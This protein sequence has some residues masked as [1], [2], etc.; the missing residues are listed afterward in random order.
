MQ[1]EISFDRD[2]ALLCR[3]E[4]WEMETVARCLK[5]EI[6]RLEK[7]IEK[8]DNDPDNEGQVDFL[9]A[10]RELRYQISEIKE[11]INTLQNAKNQ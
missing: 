2:R 1:T 4:K 9:E 10:K 11:I 3:F 5:P 8:I 7:Q 6:K